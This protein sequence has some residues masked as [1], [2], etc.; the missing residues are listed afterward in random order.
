MYEDFFEEM[1]NMQRR[2]DDLFNKFSSEVSTGLRKPLSDVSETDEEIKLVIDMPG[3]DKD[4]ID[5]SVTDDGLEIVAEKEEKEEEKLKK[6][7]R[8]Y[9]GFSRYFSLPENADI[10]NIKATYD[11]G[12]LEITIPKKRTEKKKK[13]KKIKVK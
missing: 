7:E 8:R 9:S 11:K 3:M 1:R 12:V 6:Y 10:E 13:K 5:I 2:M 4:D